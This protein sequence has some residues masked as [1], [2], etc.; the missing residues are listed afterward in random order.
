MKENN[1]NNN[2]VPDPVRCRNQLAREDDGER[3]LQKV[4]CTLS[5]WLWYAK[6]LQ[7]LPRAAHTCNSPRWLV[8]G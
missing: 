5:N 1:N 8:L 4:P 2:L 6:L 3:G 7:G